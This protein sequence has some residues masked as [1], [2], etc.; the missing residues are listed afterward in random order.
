MRDHTPARI[1]PIELS[2]RGRQLRGT[3]Y[4]PPDG[5]PRPVAIL[6]HGF[7]GQRTE[8]SRSFVQLARR[9]VASGVAAVAMDRAG[10]GESDGDFADT[11]VSGDVADCIAVVE[12]V[13]ADP[14]FDPTN[15]HLTGTSLGAVVASIDIAGGI[16]GAGLIQAEPTSINL[17]PPIQVQVTT[18][19]GQV[20]SFGVRLLSAAGSRHR[21]SWRLLNQ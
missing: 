8:A 6:H 20:Y 15:L 11:T 14:R 17:A 7:G 4:L 21:V 10:H 12:F 2:I 13:A 5:G 9:L 16:A 1:E 18:L 19:R 3:R